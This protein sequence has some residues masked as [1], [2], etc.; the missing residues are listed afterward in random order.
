MDQ[1]YHTLFHTHLMY[2]MSIIACGLFITA[3]VLAIISYK[4]KNCRNAEYIQAKVYDME[5][6]NDEIEKLQQPTK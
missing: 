6:D 3:I 2:V 4:C 5:T 1:I